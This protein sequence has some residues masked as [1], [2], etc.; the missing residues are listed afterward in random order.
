MALVG[1]T[2]NNIFS[3]IYFTP[4]TILFMWLG[5]FF[6]NYLIII[7]SGMIPFITTLN[8]YCLEK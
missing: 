5:I 3:F 1:Y 8:L 7:A 6:G 4:L 2:F